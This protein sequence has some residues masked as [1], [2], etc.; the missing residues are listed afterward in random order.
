M[1]VN[2]VESIAFNHEIYN[3]GC[4]LN[5]HGWRSFQLEESQWNFKVWNW[6]AINSAVIINCRVNNSNCKSASNSRRKGKL[7]D[8]VS[9]L[10]LEFILVQMKSM[11]D[12][13]NLFKLMCSLV[14][15]CQPITGCL[16]AKVVKTLLRR[17]EIINRRSK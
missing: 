14:T 15:M 8:L 3:H 9:S 6:T 13:S 17:V 11:I 1:I 5:R 16:R 2:F 7:I 4:H 10:H 12:F